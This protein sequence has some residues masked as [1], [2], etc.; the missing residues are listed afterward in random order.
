MSGFN[1][2]APN[3]GGQQGQNPYAQQQAGY[4]PYAQQQQQQQY[5][6]YGQQQY[7]QP[8]QQQQYYQQPPQQGYNQQY[9]QQQYGQQQYGQQQQYGHQQ[10][11][12]QQG[13]GG[14]QQY[15]G[16]YQQNNQYGRGGNQG[17]GRGGGYNHQNQ[18]GGGY[19]HQNQ[20][21]QSHYNQQQQFHGNQAQQQ[22][23]DNWDDSDEEDPAPQ[24]N[25]KQHQIPSLDQSGDEAQ[26]DA[27]RKKTKKRKRKKNKNKN[28]GNADA[29]N[30]NSGNNGNA[31]A[32]NVNAK[33]SANT[34]ASPKTPNADDAVN[35]SPKSKTSALSKTDDDDAAVKE[36]TEK[37]ENVTV[38]EP[39]QEETKEATKAATKEVK[40]EKKQKP[41]PPPPQK[42]K[43]KEHNESK[44]EQKEKTSKDKPKMKGKPKWD[45]HDEREHMNLVL[46]GH[47]DAGK[48]TISGQIL[49]AT[50]QI[51]ERTIAK[52]QKEA[53]EK[54]RE[55][56]WIAYIMDEDDDERN[57]GKTVEC[58][59]AHFD[60]KK[61][62]YTILDAPGHKNYV[63]NMISGASQAD[64]AILVVSAR[65]GE[66]E[67]GFDR[68]GQTREHGLLVKTLG[69]SRVVVA[70]NKMDTCKW[71]TER[72]EHI[73]KRVVDFLTTDIGF[74]AKYVTVLPISG[75]NAV[76]IKVPV[77]KD[78][79]PWWN[80]PTLLQTLDDLKKIKRAVGDNLRI[81][82][83]D[84][85]KGDKGLQ[86]IGKVES[87]VIR[88]GET[89]QIMPSEATAKILALSVD[90]TPVDAA[91]AGENILIT[92]DT[93][94][95]SLTMDQI[96]SGCVICLE[97]D[98]AKICQSFTAEI[99]V[100]DLPGGIMTV[101][102]S[103][104][105]HCHNVA[106]NCEIIAIPHKVHKKTRK[107]SK[108]PPPFLRV[109]ENAIV[110]IEL[111]ERVALESYDDCAVLGRFT[112]RDQ[113]KTVV[114][115]KVREI[116]ESASK[117][118]DKQ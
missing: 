65:R 60:T 56:W 109:K 1:P 64:V 91:G 81:P 33:A 117:R 79:C 113:G 47:V 116:K 114:I 23:Q 5:N 19:G 18:G 24:Q 66:F 45:K 43:K 38:S 6:P 100:N 88:V 115:G 101:G 26:P 8:P 7:H 15:G 84:R 44:E 78:E 16:Q 55:S 93:G 75:Q 57:K 92:F 30:G 14:Q 61:R 28:K 80:G 62:R 42:S 32:A 31:N 50:N 29:N 49:L 73:K 52:Y 53:K 97:E 110:E 82:V 59:R 9:G 111:K 68:G 20:Y 12:G 108:V 70:I 10:Q 17:G 90:D 21:D 99:Y 94:K 71:D 36:V 96:Y 102:Y 103:A 112:L 41:E 76:N 74:K 39:K 35:G 25:V 95:Y 89:V 3:W 86:A 63:P 85:Y 34:S 107:R 11:F 48:S 22:R 106:A 37:I 51:D 105:F 72:Y 58:G 118:R 2:N 69:I 104:M 98:P 87:G 4:N 46:I 54:N 40:K 67:A 77:G 83:L 27:P 13:Y